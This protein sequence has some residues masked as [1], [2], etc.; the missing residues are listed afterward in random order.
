MRAEEP[1]GADRGGWLFLL[2][3]PV[4]RGALLSDLA[5]T[6]LAMPVALFPAVNA[7]RFGDDPRTLGL[8]LS[9]IAAG[10]ILAGSA[11]GRSP[12]PPARPGV[13]GLRRRWGL[14][15][16]GFGLVDGVAATLACLAVAGAADTFSVI[17]RG[18]VVQLD[19]PDSH[20]GRAG[21]AEY[22]VGAGGPALG[23]TRAGLVA[24]AST[25]ELA[26]L[27]GGLACVLAVAVIAVTHPGLRGGRPPTRRGEA[28]SGRVGVTG[29]SDGEACFGTG[30]HLASGCPSRRREE[31]R[32]PPQ[33][34]TPRPRKP[35][36]R[37]PWSRRSRSTACAV[38]TDP[39]S[40]GAGPAIAAGPAFDPIAATARSPQVSLRPEPFGALVYHFGTRRLSFL[41]TPELFAVVSG[42][43]EHPTVHAAI[44]AA[45]VEPAQRPAYLKA[46]AGLAANGTI[47]ERQVK[48]VDHFQYGLN[49][50]ICLTWELTY[51]C[52]LACVHCLSSSGGATR[53]S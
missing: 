26:A 39:Q 17:A 3:R 34:T 16:A 41:K 2:R 47:E 19:T 13:A 52:N 6:L 32:W 44:D 48:L 14:A 20:R 8:F 42:L 33:R 4:L 30:C 46:L 15:L 53:A 9:A 11:P 31:C 21:S 12:G 24:G 7:E 36:S 35:S 45:G 38:S 25:P 28:P 50:P 37:S 49:S 51:A 10:G 27:T 23:N 5:S 1:A 18:T 22:A 43:A 29:R 40:T